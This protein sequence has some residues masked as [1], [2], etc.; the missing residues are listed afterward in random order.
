MPVFLAA[1]MIAFRP[2][3]VFESMG[4][5]EK[6]LLEASVLLLTK[7]QFILDCVVRTGSANHTEGFLGVLY[8]YLRRFKAWKIPDEARLTGRIRN[9]LVALYQADGHLASDEPEDSKLRVGFRTQITRLRLKLQQIAGAAELAKFDASGVSSVIV[10]GGGG[11]VT[12]AGR[13]TNEQLAHE[14][15]MDSDFKLDDTGSMGS[16]VFHRIRN[17]FHQV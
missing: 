10:S 9:A 15:L 3:Q 13:M 14:I 4:A 2:S 12:L 11:C 17:S 7:F 6:E 5:L 8:E 16:L 1:F